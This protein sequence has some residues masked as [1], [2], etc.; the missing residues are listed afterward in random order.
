[1][2]HNS[3]LLFTFLTIAGCKNNSVAPTEM[4]TLSVSMVND[5]M[6]YTFAIPKSSF[7]IHDTLQATMTVTDVGTLPETL[8]VNYGWL[9]W[10][11]KDSVGRTVA[12]G[13]RVVSMYLITE[14]IKPQESAL[15]GAISQT[16]VDTT[17][18]Q[19]QPGSYLLSVT[20]SSLSLNLTIQ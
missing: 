5:N 14:I 10:T 3:L 1:M 9:A 19:L 17:G 18:Y 12:Y 20:N 6:K 4:P 15:T 13:P 8:Q 11:L 16:L 7:S 2:K